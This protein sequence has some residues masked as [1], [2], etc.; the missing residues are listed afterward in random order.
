MTSAVIERRELKNIEPTA[1]LH[2][3]MCMEWKIVGTVWSLS[4]EFGLRAGVVCAPGNMWYTPEE[5]VGLPCWARDLNCAHDHDSSKP[6]NYQNSDSGSPCL[7]L[8]LA[9][10]PP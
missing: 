2:I 7:Y 1:F 9:L 5:E 3:E 10:V 6:Q 4:D 8:I